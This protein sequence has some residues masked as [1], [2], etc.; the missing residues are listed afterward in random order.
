MDTPQPE[1][2]AS[3]V[4]KPAS[5]RMN[6]PLNFPVIDWR[7]WV[8][9][10]SIFY[11]ASAVCILVGVY[12]VVVPL[13]NQP[14]IAL[15]KFGCLATLN[16]YE[17]LVIAIT[18]LIVLWRH[19]T[20]DAVLLAFLIAAFLIGSATAL[21]TVAPDFPGP[22]LAFGAAGLLLAMAKVYTLGRWI[23]GR[24]SRLTVT[25]LVFLLAWNFLMP[26]VLG[27][28]MSHGLVVAPLRQAWLTGGFVTLLGGT[29]L[30]A[31]AWRLPTGGGAINDSG[32]PFLST[33]VMRWSLILLSLVGV[34]VHQYALNW[35]FG[36][37]FRMMDLLSGLAVL[38]LLIIELRRAYDVRPR[39]SDMLPL[40]V[41]LFAVIACI[42]S[43]AQTV[44]LGWNIGVVSF[45]PI[46]ALAMAVVI[47]IMAWRRQWIVLHK[48]AMGYLIVACWGLGAA[49]HAT[50]TI[51]SGWLLVILAFPIL[52]L[53]AVV[54]LLKPSL[55]RVVVGPGSV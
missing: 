44:R 40:V 54:S 51:R 38:S 28:I 7:P 13:Y 17:L 26:G 10:G 16:I 8:L 35:A 34:F 27:L 43:D 46:V 50:Q 19:V 15:E 33:S 30:I 14:D 4:T 55:P 23:T 6:T 18:L 9:G 41:T 12:Q 22:T 24:M 1:S 5:F 25:G 53:G 2:S 20:D 36:L 48:M 47:E 31:A 39:R 32:K 42:E 45:A 37:N 11:L 29:V 3:R 52:L 49:I 21:D